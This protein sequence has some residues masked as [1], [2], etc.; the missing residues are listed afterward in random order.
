MMQIIEVEIVNKQKD[1]ESGDAYYTTKVKIMEP[2]AAFGPQPDTEE[3]K[4]KLKEKLNK[5]FRRIK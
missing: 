1:E 5:G 4:N 2:G 3:L